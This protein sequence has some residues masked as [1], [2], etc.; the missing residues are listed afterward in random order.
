[1]DALKA[2]LIQRDLGKI[3]ANIL[4][5]LQTREHKEVLDFQKAEIYRES[6]SRIPVLPEVLEC[7][8]NNL[9]E[10]LNV[11]DLSVEVI[12]THDTKSE[13]HHHDDSYALVMFLGWKERL[14]NPV[15]AHYY[16]GD[17][18]TKHVAVPGI[19][20]HILPKTIHG[21]RPSPG[22]SITFLSV[23]S[24]RIIEDFHPVEP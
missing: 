11:D 6:W 7:W 18:T 22:N 16:F 24:K 1:M 19:A 21:F 8:R 5:L 2:S 3:S 9:C 13:I 15:N 23:Q 14:P 10:Y 17:S 4:F 20:L 12:T